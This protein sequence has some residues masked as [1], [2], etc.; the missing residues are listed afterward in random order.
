[1]AVDVKA[2]ATLETGMVRPLFRTSIT[3]SSQ[4]YLYAAARDG[5]RFLIRQTAGR[6]GGQV[7]QLN[8]VTNWT[9]LVR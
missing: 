7:E 8:V 9:S 3:T 2:G 6:E 1:M 5:K 4:V